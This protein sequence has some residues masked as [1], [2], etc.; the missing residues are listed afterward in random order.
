MKTAAFPYSSSG[1]SLIELLVVLSVIGI[2]AGVGLSGTKGIQNWMAKTRT[3]DLF[4]NLELS[5]RLYK[6]DNGSWPPSLTGGEVQINETGNQWR[7]DLAIYLKSS[8]KEQT[9]MDGYGNADIRI[10]LDS[11]GDKRIYPEE[12]P[13]L[14]INYIL[15]DVWKQVAIYSLDA[16][17]QVIATNWESK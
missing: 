4:S 12:M 5:C 8:A 15:T 9:Y 11:D 13:G 14:P 2:M 1:F 3:A 7:D 16:D 10:V 17:G 6:Y